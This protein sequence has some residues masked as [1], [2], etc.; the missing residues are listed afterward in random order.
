MFD[1]GLVNEK[2]SLRKETGEAHQSR[3]IMCR[4]S[5]AKK[6]LAHSQNN[7]WSQRQS[8]KKGSITD[9]GEGVKAR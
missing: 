8:E 1:L 2:A 5:E 7:Q 6:T 3:N 9:V 4:G